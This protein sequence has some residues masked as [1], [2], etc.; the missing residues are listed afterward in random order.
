[1]PAA[2]GAAKFS[3]NKKI[4]ADFA[5][6]SPNES[7]RFD[8]TGDADGD[9]GVAARVTGFAADDG[10]IEFLRG[11]IESAI[12]A[13]DPTCRCCGRHD[14]R[15]LS[16]LRNTRHGGKIA[17]RS[18]HRF[19]TNER[20]IGRGFEMNLFDDAIGLEEKQIIAASRPNDSAIIARANEHILAFA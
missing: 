1:M 9:G 14:E 3:G 8:K 20:G 2:N 12:K 10:D 18:H 4:V 6:A 15:D 19:P 7:I 13:R 16:K 5:A 11:A 17:Q